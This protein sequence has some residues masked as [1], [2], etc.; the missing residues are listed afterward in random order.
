MATSSIYDIGAA[1]RDDMRNTIGF[2]QRQA[3]IVI[4][5]T[6]RQVEVDGSETTY[7]GRTP[8]KITENFTAIDIEFLDFYRTSRREFTLPSSLSSLTTYPT[9][10]S[11]TRMINYWPL[12]GMDIILPHLIMFVASTQAHS[13]EFEKDAYYLVSYPKK[14]MWVKGA[15]HVDLYDRTE[16]IPLE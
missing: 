16:L 6:Q 9:T 8:Q 15:S 14:L 2:Q 1:S 12:T 7:N 3:M 4:R 5:I 11:I 10:S 13:Q